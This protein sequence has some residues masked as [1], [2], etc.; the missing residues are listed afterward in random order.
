[1]NALAEQCAAE[2]DG[3][4]QGE[5]R[6]FAW[7]RL[8]ERVA[9]GVDRFHLLVDSQPRIAASLASTIRD[10]RDAGV[11][12]S[13]LP[14]G[15]SDLRALYERVEAALVRLGETA[16]L[17]DRIGL[18]RLGA[19]GARAFL[20]RIGVGNARVS[21]ATELVGSQGDLLQAIADV[22]PLELR[23]PG[24]EHPHADAV[25]KRWPWTFDVV[26]LGASPDPEDVRV[27]PVQGGPLEELEHVASEVLELLDRG[28]APR[29]VVVVARTLEPY[30]SW[31]GPVFERYD[32]P[33]SSSVSES[34]LLHPA[35]RRLFHLARVLLCDLDADA[36]VEL[37][38]V[39]GLLWG[40]SSMDGVPEL[41][42]R[43]AC[44]SGLTHGL[45]AWTDAL[46][47]EDLLRDRKSRPLGGAR[48]SLRR[49]L[50]ALRSDVNRLRAAGSWSA[51]VDALL[52]SADRW[53]PPIVEDP[54]R[55]LAE[56]ARKA[57]QELRSL[58]AVDGATPGS[59]PSSAQLLR[60]I[61]EALTARS[62]R[63]YSGNRGDVR[64]LDAI[65]ARAIEIS[66][67]FM[68]GTN[69]SH[70]PRPLE[71]DPFLPDETRR[72][73]RE[74]LRRPVPV[75]GENETEEQ[76]LFALLLSQATASIT[77]T[78]HQTDAAGRAA[79]PTP[80]LRDLIGR[81]PSPDQLRKA[82]YEP[83]DRVPA[84]KTSVLPARVALLESAI[85]EGPGSASVL[86]TRLPPEDARAIQR[87]LDHLEAVESVEPVDLRYDG[88]VG[89]EAVP[90]PSPLRPTRL[91]TL[92]RCPLRGFFRDVLHVPDREDGSATELRANEVGTLVHQVLAT[93][94]ESLADRGFL[95]TGT[96]VAEATA[97]AREAIGD[98]LDS[99]ALP[100]TGGGFGSSLR[101][102]LRDQ[103]Q[104]AIEE[105]V[106]WDL[107]RLLPGG[108]SEIR[109]EKS[110]EG[111]IELENASVLVGGT[112]D[113][114][115]HSDGGIRVSDY[116]T[117]GSPDRLTRTGEVEAGR[118]LQLPLY[119][120]G[121]GDRTGAE[122]VRAEILHIP[123]R[124]DRSR[125]QGRDRSFPL[126]EVRVETIRQQIARPMEILSGLLTNGAFPFRHGDD[127]RHCPY[128]VACRH[129]HLPTVARIRDAEVFAEYFEIAGEPP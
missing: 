4:V 68:I 63:P 84:R 47:R 10:L 123:L 114:E 6:G 129:T 80:Y 65:Q 17:Y 45:D 28:A 3:D 62:V 60:T 72:H 77:A 66:H 103:L 106:A 46:S 12:P 78:F 24:A 53:L 96:D 82:I 83:G 125:G 25:R 117:G 87:G 100:P 73:L 98:A 51:C 79:A 49:I 52:R 29:D 76:F 86:A 18:F 107:P 118:A 124:P 54:E 94:Y 93:V 81:S 108:V 19:R 33:F 32:I 59:P 14:N 5:L 8:V 127:C 55:S 7:V 113:R 95:R 42:E 15:V 110:Y 11:A 97:A 37:L 92:G 13:D 22:V 38:R 91:E 70:W 90:D 71:E 101:D 74:E 30:A 89:R 20:H 112:I 85:R 64:I 9:S 23:Q 57:L 69:E 44:A 31:V 58:D 88:A 104:R 27:M 119:A 126:A 43:V 115:V 40:A 75:R 2:T 120:V 56:T 61:E 116:K 21:G 35:A 105:F 121:A 39:P 48:E 41:A 34:S 36:V 1:M 109:C 128:T 102:G 99:R 16:G 26:P 67:L 50:L 122:E 111:E